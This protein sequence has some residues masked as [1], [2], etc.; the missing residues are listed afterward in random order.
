MTHLTSYR[1]LAEVTFKIVKTKD[2][3]EGCQD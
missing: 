1:L 3:L 2:S